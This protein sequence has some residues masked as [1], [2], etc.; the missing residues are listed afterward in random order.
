MSCI[1]TRQ[2]VYQPSEPPQLAGHFSSSAAY[3]A[4]R[5]GG[6][7][8]KEKKSAEHG[9]RAALC[10]VRRPWPPL[11]ARRK[12]FGLTNGGPPPT[13]AHRQQAPRGRHR[14]RC[15]CN[16]PPP[17]QK[18]T[19]VSSW[20]GVSM[21]S[22]A[23]YMATHTH[24]HAHPT[25]QPSIHPSIHPRSHTHTHTHSHT[26]PLSTSRYKQRQ[27]ADGSKS[28][29]RAPLSPFHLVF[30]TSAEGGVV[31]FGGAAGRLGQ[32]GGPLPRPGKKR[33]VVGFRAERRAT[34]AGV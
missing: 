25:N 3:W 27:I 4:R 32:G 6:E 1:C 8:E 33:H 26:A 11:S 20:G 28:V 14:C 24:T 5:G 7:G 22:L 12:H 16:P 30:P 29:S 9:R 19:C 21:A 31:P 13:Q 15:R 34:R 18:H 10:L 17:P 23:I 2:Q